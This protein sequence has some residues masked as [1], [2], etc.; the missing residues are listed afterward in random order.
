MSYS[1]FMIFMLFLSILY[2]H[3][4]YSTRLQKMGAGKISG[5]WPTR[6]INRSACFRKIVF[7]Q[8]RSRFQSQDP[9]SEME[10]NCTVPAYWLQSDML[11][12]SLW[13]CGD[14]EPNWLPGLIP[15]MTTFR[16]CPAK[17]WPHAEIRNPLLN[18]QLVGGLEHEFYLSIYWE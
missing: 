2:A 17:P 6:R 14:W 18:P 12:L 10:K 13:I 15:G 3:L 7:G 11:F 8:K 1:R 16:S 4:C 5:N 9:K